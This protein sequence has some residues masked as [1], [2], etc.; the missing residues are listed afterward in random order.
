MFDSV[1]TE[2]GIS[3]SLASGVTD[4]LRESI[5]SILPEGATIKVEG[6]DQNMT[7]STAVVR[8]TLP[9]G[10]SQLYEIT[11]TRDGLSWK[12][13][14]VEVKYQSQGGEE[15]VVDESSTMT[16][17]GT[18]VS[19]STSASDAPAQDE[20]STDTDASADEQVDEEVSE[21]DAE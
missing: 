15:P 8:A 13:T 2:E 20:E 12:V 10:G 6:I 4:E 16:V 19:E 1:G 9:D 17:S 5:E 3:G 18:V 11:L 14:G 21:D 7:S